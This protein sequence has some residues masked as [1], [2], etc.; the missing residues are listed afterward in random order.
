MCIKLLAREL[1][2]TVYYYFSFCKSYFPVKFCKLALMTLHFKMHFTV[3]PNLKSEH[4]YRKI[5]LF[6]FIFLF[7]DMSRVS[8]NY[9]ERCANV[10]GY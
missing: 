8:R 4:C 9:F 2:I 10:R 7:L 3:S 6:S 1:L 5:S